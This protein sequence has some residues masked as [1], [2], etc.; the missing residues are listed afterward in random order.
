MN[1]RPLVL[2]LVI[3]LVFGG[4]IASTIWVLVGDGGGGND[5]VAAVCGVVERTP[6]PTQDTP[7]EE[8]RRWGVGEVMPS[9]AKANPEYKPLADAMEKAVHAMQSLDFDAM[10]EAVDQAKSLCADV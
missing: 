4:A 6:L 1:V 8:L 5:D 3:G 9:V 7:I 10:K 2:G